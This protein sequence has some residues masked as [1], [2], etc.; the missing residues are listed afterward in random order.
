M[1]G[2]P[3]T[4]GIGRTHEA[5]VGRTK[6]GLPHEAWPGRAKLGSGVR[7]VQAAFALLLRR[8]RG[9]SWAV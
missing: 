5:S 2:W 7:F 1:V 8:A 6:P 3:L 9:S 4:K